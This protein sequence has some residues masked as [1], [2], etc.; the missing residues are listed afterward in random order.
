MKTNPL[1]DS[2]DVREIVR[3]TYGKIA[4][5]QQN[6]C[7]GATN[8]G[9]CAPER[10]SATSATKLGYSAKEIAALPGDADLGLGCGKCESRR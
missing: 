7:C 4:T 1:S 2:N 6:G 8:S 10:P 9:R 3:E 5:G